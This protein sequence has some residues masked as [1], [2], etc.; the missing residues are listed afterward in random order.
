M[1]DESMSE[2]IR[3]DEDVA[4]G[5]SARNEIIVAAAK[6]EDTGF[7]RDNHQNVFLARSVSEVT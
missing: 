1:P 3:R 2:S 7:N 4:E 5:L 6:D